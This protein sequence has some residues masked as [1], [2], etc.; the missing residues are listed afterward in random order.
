MSE[1]MS[2]VPFVFPERRRGRPRTF[3]EPMT[4]V[5]TYIPVRDFD[6]LDRIAKQQNTS[7]SDVIRRVIAR[8]SR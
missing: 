7:I 8:R 5:M 2:G 3:N 1:G 4:S 6:R